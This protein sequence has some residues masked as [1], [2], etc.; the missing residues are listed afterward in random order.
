MIASRCGELAITCA[1]ESV[2]DAPKPAMRWNRWAG[3]T[4]IVGAPATGSPVASGGCSVSRFALSPVV[5]QTWT[6]PVSP[7]PGVADAGD[8]G[9]NARARSTPIT[10]PAR[11]G[12]A[13]RLLTK[14]SRGAGFVAMLAGPRPSVN[15]RPRRRGAAPGRVRPLLP[16]QMLAPSCALGAALATDTCA[17]RAGAARAVA[18]L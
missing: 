9:D 8:T 17:A 6:R 3:S 7:E 5:I 2:I 16:R 14:S 18:R 1:E 15:R 12:V 10:R 13:M 11:R 4:S